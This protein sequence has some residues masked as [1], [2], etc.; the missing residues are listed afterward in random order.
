[1]EIHYKQKSQQI[2]LFVYNRL[3]NHEAHY[4]NV[5]WTTLRGNTSFWFVG[6]SQY[7]QVRVHTDLTIL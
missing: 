4:L 6:K 1:M 2:Y 7:V 5:L 3:L